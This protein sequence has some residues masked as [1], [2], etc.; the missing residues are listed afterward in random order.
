MAMSRF[1]FK[2]QRFLV[3]G[4]TS[5]RA[6]RLTREEGQTFVEYALVLGVVSVALIGAATFLHD[7]IG[8]FYTDIAN[9]FSAAVH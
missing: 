5:A 7:K 6:P 9:Q 1:T 3:V 4:L 2:F 8:A